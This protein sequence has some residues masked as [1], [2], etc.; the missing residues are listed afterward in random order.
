MSKLLTPAQAAELLGISVD[1]L[2]TWRCKKRYDL[3]YVKV[4]RS[5]KYREDDVHAFIESR[6]RKP[7][8]L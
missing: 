4:G 2:S 8:K 3:P 1:T 7:V 6:V 5:V